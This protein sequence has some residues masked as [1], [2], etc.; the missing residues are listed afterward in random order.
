MMIKVAVSTVQNDDL[1][2]EYDKSSDGCATFRFSTLWQYKVCHTY[3]LHSKPQNHKY[4]PISSFA[5]ALSL[6]KRC[7]S[8][9]KRNKSYSTYYQYYC[10]LKT[11]NND[12]QYQF[13]TARL[14]ASCLSASR[15]PTDST[16]H[17][18]FGQSGDTEAVHWNTNDSRPRNSV[19]GTV[20]P[21]MMMMSRIAFI[22]T[23]QVQYVVYGIIDIIAQ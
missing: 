21:L 23:Y 13:T 7:R 15:I 2:R 1:S 20:Q 18:S 16:Q 11:S 8:T 6:E 3:T 5:K 10:E 22:T 9:E 14:S 17:H 4:E 19:T 12:V